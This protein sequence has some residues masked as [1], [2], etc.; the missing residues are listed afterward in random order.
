[1]TSSCTVCA[2]K[3]IL[4]LFRLWTFLST[5]R[6]N[7]ILDIVDS[8][9][10]TVTLDLYITVT[11]NG[12]DGVSNHQPHDYLLNLLF[13]RISRKHQSSAS[14]PLCEELTGDRWIPSTNGQERGK[15]F[16]WMTSSWNDW[17]VQSSY[18]VTKWL[19]KMTMSS[20]LQWLHMSVM[21]YKSAKTRL[22]CWPV[23]T[24]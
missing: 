17:C 21:A 10:Y 8:G 3:H 24:Y 13:R 22:F 15:C 2:L 14:W 7:A 1:M 9:I 12:H 18:I 6:L 5:S 16:H 11:Y 20:S 19:P 4:V 23:S